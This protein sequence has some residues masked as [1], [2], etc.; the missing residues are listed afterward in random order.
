MAEEWWET[1]GRYPQGD[2]KGSMN[3]WRGHASSAVAPQE[4]DTSIELR[5][6]PFW[7]ELLPIFDKYYDA[8]VGRRFALAEV[9]ADLAVLHGMIGRHRQPFDSCYVVADSQSHNPR[10]K[11]ER[12]FRRS[13]FG[14]LLAAMR[15]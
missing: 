2:P 13:G 3:W 11:E 15:R 4:N 7:D 9:E 1:I 6:N 12:R 8:P 5:R 10:V 14:R